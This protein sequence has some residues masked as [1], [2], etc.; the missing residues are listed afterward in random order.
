[1][2]LP[3]CSP[4]APEVSESHTF[5]VNQTSNSVQIDQV[6]TTLQS[7]VRANLQTFLD[8]FGNALMKYGGAKGFQELYK[9][10][11]GAFKYTSQVNEALQGTRTHDLSGLIGNL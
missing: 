5:P 7:D 2:A 9:S 10:S 1:C 6:L 8:Q 3:I 4:N 11:A